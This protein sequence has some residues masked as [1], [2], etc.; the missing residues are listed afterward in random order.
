MTI[1][2][3]VRT[4]IAIQ[5][6]QDQPAKALRIRQY[7]FHCECSISKAE[8][9][10]DIVSASVGHSDVRLTIIVQISHRDRVWIAIGRDDG[11]I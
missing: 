11:V 2:G 4:T 7:D 9:H 3:Q 5:I 8:K 10:T 1:H 6:T